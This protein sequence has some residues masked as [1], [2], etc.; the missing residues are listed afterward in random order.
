MSWP[1]FLRLRALVV[2]NTELSLYDSVCSVAER[3]ALMELLHKL[4][5][6]SGRGQHLAEG[7]VTKLG[8]ES[9]LFMTSQGV[10]SP[11]SPHFASDVD[12]LSKT[13]ISL[14]LIPP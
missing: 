1:W 12:A 5:S 9:L 11:I 2:R 13:F 10:T 6:L 7:A 4:D 14:I 3:D 8:E